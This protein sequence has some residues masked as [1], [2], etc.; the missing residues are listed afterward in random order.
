[1]KYI[2]ILIASI[3]FSFGN[4]PDEIYSQ[5]LKNID[6][7]TIDLS[8]Y[9]GKKMIIIILPVSSQDTSV[10]V[11]DL[12]NMTAQNNSLLIIGVPAIE[13]GYTDAVK[14]ELKT[15]YLG[16]GSNFILSEGMAVKK[17]SGTAQ[18]P[19]FQWLTKMEKN[20]HFNMDVTGIGDKFL[21]NGKGR[22]FAVMGPQLKLSNP[23]LSQVLAKPRFN[24]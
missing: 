20:Q 24:N 1:M 16:L 9:S 17:T 11:S 13:M 7:D 12:I 3:G 4:A 14:T 6:G 15:R 22:L 18:A 2:F 10:S 5:P 8:N 21:V 19:I 23:V